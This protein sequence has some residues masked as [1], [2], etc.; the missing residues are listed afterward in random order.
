M[1]GF[2]SSPNKGQTVVRKRYVDENNKFYSYFFVL[3]LVNTCVIL[4]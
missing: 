3:S 2:V 1:R 4:Y